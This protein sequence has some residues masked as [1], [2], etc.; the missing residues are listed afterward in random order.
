MVLNSSNLMAF[1]ATTNPIRACA[2]YEKALGLTL[3]EDTPF[4]LVFDANGIM[5]R[6]Q[7]VQSLEPATHTVLGWKVPDIR[8]AIGAL[9]RK[10]IRFE[11]YPGLAQDEMGV[12]SSPSGAKV[13]WFEDPD[14]N[15]LSLTQF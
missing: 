14:G 5:L 10:K 4:A 1:V 3:L 7:K 13:A 12:W 15:I 9:V 2:F 8:K 11:R 6:V